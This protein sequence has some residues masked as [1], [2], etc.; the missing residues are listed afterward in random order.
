MVNGY[1]DEM[2]SVG[3]SS[4]SR[5]SWGGGKWRILAAHGRRRAQEILRIKRQK[6][7]M[8]IRMILLL[9]R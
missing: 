7:E 4:D 9:H 2:L 6:R 8:V 1:R 5:D 3:E